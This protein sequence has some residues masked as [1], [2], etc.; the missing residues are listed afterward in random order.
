LTKAEN[1]NKKREAAGGAKGGKPGEWEEEEEVEEASDE[2][3]ETKSPSG[4]HKEEWEKKRKHRTK[5][6]IEREALLIGDLY[7]MLDLS[8]RT[9]EAGDSEIKAAYRKLALMYHPDKIGEAITQSDKE[10]WLKI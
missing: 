7:A 1:N 3:E 4:G 10:I 2:D 9:Y 5:E 8:D 6:D